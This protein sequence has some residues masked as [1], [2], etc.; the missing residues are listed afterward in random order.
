M[1]RGIAATASDGTAAEAAQNALTAGGSAADAL[2]AGF[3][4]AAGARPGVL[5]APAIA[6]VAGTGVGARVFDGR[7]AQPGLGAAR[8]RGFVDAASVP[9]AARVAAPRTLGMLSLL[10]GYLGRT[11]MG[12]LAR[13]GILAAT[14]AGATE[15]AELIKQV[16]A[17]G[18]ATL[19][20]RAVSRAL[21]AAGGV[22][23]GGTLTED[24]LRE[25]LPGSGDALTTELPGD[26]EGSDPITLVRSPFPAG[27][28]A[29][30]AEIIVACDGRGMLAALAY[31][32][33]RLGVIV[34]ELEI[35]LGHDAVPVRRGVPRT[36]PGTVLP[37]AT[38]IAVL[39]RGRF[40]AA[41]GLE[42]LP[43]IDNR[44]LTSLT[45]RLTFET[46]WDASLETRLSELRLQ[47]NARRALAAVRDGQNAKA[48]IQGKITDD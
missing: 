1:I 43:G 40:A 6:L 29:R 35:E 22:I 15:R 13:N 18:G 24:D 31:A 36:T 33:A 38:P 27:A 23:A 44:T 48:L 16:G 4:A 46:G 8:P 47:T 32:P 45:E 17:S 5:L 9:H 19:Q 39:Q 21:L 2:I 14:H 30:P 26:P 11:R 37:M 42:R 3:L 34:A 20:L 25:N 10:H 7:A 12:E 28:E 41:V